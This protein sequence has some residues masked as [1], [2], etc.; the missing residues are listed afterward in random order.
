MMENSSRYFANTSCEYYPCH[1]GADAQ[2]F[3]CMFCYCPLYGM[4]TAC[5]GNFKF[6]GAVKDCSDCLFPHMP[7]SYDAIIKALCSRG[8]GSF[9][10]PMSRSAEMFEQAMAELEGGT[11]SVV[12]SSR[13]RAYALLADIFAEAGG[14]VIVPKS[15]IDTTCPSLREI[16]ASR[17][18]EIDA[19]DM[20]HP[21]GAR[22]AICES[23]LAVICEAISDPAVSVP[24][25][26]TISGVAHRMGVPC[27]VDCSPVPSL[28]RALEWGADIIVSTTE[29]IAS[30]DMPTRAVVTECGSF[31]W[32]A[33]KW[34]R[35]ATQDAAHGNI[36]FSEQYGHSALAERLRA[37]AM[38]TDGAIPAELECWLLHQSMQTLRLRMAK[39]C[40]NAMRVAEYLQARDEVKWVRYPGLPSHHQNDFAR[41]FFGTRFSPL[42]SFALDDARDPGRCAEAM[43][44]ALGGHST[45]TNARATTD[46]RIRLRI[47]IEDVDDITRAIG[48][49]ISL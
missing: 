36:I 41:Q 8:D 15:Y 40:F 14:R 25:L 32:S 9:G 3:S 18:I 42:L 27:I 2:T 7:S 16:L 47:G 33:K 29:C 37:D 46:G 5:G 20:D 13:E 35:L 43:T 6:T 21:C 48:A 49:A 23:T 11:A 10:T 26:E 30:F 45:S 1:D 31:D 22:D 44:N 28:Y 12:L 19:V 4:G 39:S 24:P 38:R 34:P 17:G